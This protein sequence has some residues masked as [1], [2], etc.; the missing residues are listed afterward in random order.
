M[1]LL[2]AYI[3]YFFL[4]YQI[5][6]CQTQNDTLFV[7]K[8]PV[9]SGMIIHSNKL[10]FGDPAPGI[11]I[12]STSDSIFNLS[13]G[14]VKSVF[15]VEGEFAVIV[16]DNEGDFITYAGLKET[17]VRKGDIVSLGKFIGV[18]DKNYDD[19]FKLYLIISNRELKDRTIKFLKR[20]HLV[21]M[22]NV[23]ILTDPL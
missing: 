11:L 16:K 1:K 3:V 13:K 21:S 12:T 6:F 22:V 8:I 10:F 7:K 4:F 17:V 14:I 19:I 9:R 2:L 20:R 5:A 23:A 15:N 18:I